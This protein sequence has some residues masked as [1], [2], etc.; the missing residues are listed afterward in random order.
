MDIPLEIAF[1]NMVSPPGIEDEIREHVA[2]LER[3]YNH[4]IGCRV[5]VESLHK[6]H[7]TGDLYEVHI[8]LRVPGR[9]IVVS[10]EPHHAT[11]RHASPQ[12]RTALHEAFKAAASRLTEFKAL[13]RGFVK[14]H[15]A[16]APGRVSEFLTGEDTAAVGEGAEEER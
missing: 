1:H 3:R 2:K 11:E 13:Q 12:L 4:L 8:E 6:Q 5:A 10:R 14:T 7:H 16:S 15:E 9:E